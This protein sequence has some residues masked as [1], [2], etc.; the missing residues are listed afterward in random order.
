MET[1]SYNSSPMPTST[2]AAHELP[3]APFCL[4]LDQRDCLIREMDHRIKN[5]L[6]L[7]AS[8]AQ[9]AARLEG[10]T[11]ASVAEAVALRLMTI[12]AVHNALHVASDGRSAKALPFLQG[13]CAPLAGLDHSVEVECDPSLRFDFD[14]LVPIGMAVT[15][16]VTNSLKHA[17]P[18]GRTG[19]VQV[20]LRA[21]EP[22]FQLD[23]CDDGIGPPKDLS[24]GR[25]SG[26]NLI[27]GFALQLH[28][29]AHVEDGEHGGTQ[30]SIRFAG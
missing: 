29:E 12:A 3:C 16:A 9:L 6:Q 24:C 15:E 27:G 2:T 28:G 26:L 13:V 25:G 18:K 22:G 7:L 14:T 1:C 21:V 19:R 23:V 8:Y 10:A 17:F 4:A 20:R 5:H 11:A 30:V